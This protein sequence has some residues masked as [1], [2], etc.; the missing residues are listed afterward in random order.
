M[1]KI[2]EIKK[3]KFRLYNQEIYNAMKNCYKSTNKSN[4]KKLYDIIDTDELHNIGNKFINNKKK[5]TEL[6]LDTIEYLIKFAKKMYTNDFTVLSDN[7]FD[8]IIVLFKE[9]REEPI[10]DEI[11]GQMVIDRE[12][13][14]PELK[15]NIAKANKI[16]KKECENKL[17]VDI[18]SFIK[19][20]LKIDYRGPLR[21]KLSHKYDG[22][23]IIGSFSGAKGKV[24]LTRGADEKGSDVTYIFK[25]RRFTNN[26]KEIGV[27]FEAVITEDNLKKYENERGETFSNKRSAAVSIITNSKAIKYGK[28][29]SLVPLETSDGDIISM[30]NFEDDVKYYHE[31]LVLNYDNKKDIVKTIEE[32]INNI[33]ESRDS[34]EYAIDGVVIECLNPEVQKTLGR[35][36]NINNYQIA[37][38]FPPLSKITSVKDITITVGR[39]GLI[40]PMVHYKKIILNGNEYNK[41]SLLS[42]DRFKELDLHYN[43]NIIVQYNNDVMPYVKKLSDSIING[44]KIAFPK[45]CYCGN[46]LKKIGAEYYCDNINCQERLIAAYTYFYKILGIRKLSTKTVEKLIECDVIKSYKDLLNLDYEKMVKLDRFGKKI[47]DNI[48][49]QIDNLCSNTITEAVLITALGIAG[50]VTS[51]KILT[52][53]P[54]KELINQPESL[55]DIKIDAIDKLI[56]FAFINNISKFKK[57]LL[58]FLDN[59]NIT[60]LTDEGD[61]IKIAFSGF[62]DAKFKSNLEKIGFLVKD[63]ITKDCAY[64]IIKEEGTNSRS[65]INAKKYGIEIYTLKEFADNIDKF[66]NKKLI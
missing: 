18:E 51:T 38:K 20:I 60:K 7:L 17:D 12:H 13:D 28:Y 8:K 32:K 56:K 43:E 24:Y 52:K 63:N 15:G 26:K 64:L 50:P 14:Y 10:V 19:K 55:Y 59:Y 61:K 57:H 25:D 11:V 58:F 34:L 39:T 1:K 2:L 54:L 6:D 42:Y 22:V 33:N 21:L 29:L 30:N 37:Y 31:Y 23:S 5:L 49:S 46:K 36:N 3:I 48:K 47:V 65:V 41:S 16:Y 62:R 44:E 53:I 40:T 9:Y 35:T 66:I 27:K 45:K 4:L